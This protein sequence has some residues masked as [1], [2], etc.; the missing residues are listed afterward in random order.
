MALSTSR[1]P[2][3]DAEMWM[4]GWWCSALVHELLWLL[5]LDHEGVCVKIF[6]SIHFVAEQLLDKTQESVPWHFKWTQSSICILLVFLVINELSDIALQTIDNSKKIKAAFHGVY[7]SLTLS[8][9]L[10]PDPGSGWWKLIFWC[11]L[12]REYHLWALQE[13]FR[14]FLPFLEACQHES[15]GRYCR[16]KSDVQG[17]SRNFSKISIHWDYPRLN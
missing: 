14:F 6:W 15:S 9:G 2:A 16:E 13:F 11:E 3:C 5:A 10:K 1:L 7:S 8:T 17:W 12:N 4:Y